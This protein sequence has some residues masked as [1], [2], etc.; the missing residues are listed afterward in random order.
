MIRRLHHLDE[1]RAWRES[2]PAA[3]VIGFVPTMGALHQGHGSLVQRAVAECDTTVA[4]VFVNRLQFDEAEDF[5]C[6]PRDEE[7]DCRLLAEWGAAAVWLPGHADLYPEEEPELIQPGPGGRLFEGEY[8]PGH[9]AGVLTVVAR[10]FAAVRPHRA[11]FGEKD[12]QQLFLVRELAAGLVPPV[13]IVACPTVREPDGLALSSRNRRLGPAERRRATVLH[14][15]LTA[16]RRAFV[17]GERRPERLEAA[18]REVYRAEG[19]EPEYA[20]VVDDAT[21]LP[22]TRPGGSWRAVTAARL[23]GVRLIDNLLLGRC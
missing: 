2:L 20:A 10:L 8:R 21:F 18:M 5:A 1:L 13:E 9:F 12:A 15:A 3:A 16:A 4:S 6:Y 22:P 14:R 17:A 23:G 19:I 7:A 11:Y